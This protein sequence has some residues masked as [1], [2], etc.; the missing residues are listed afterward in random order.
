MSRIALNLAILA[1]VIISA[2]VWAQ[3]KSPDE[4]QFSEQDKLRGS[5]TP[6]RAWWDLQEYHLSIEFMPESKQIRGS[7]VVTFKTLKEATK[8][9]ID[10]QEP[11]NI[12]KVTHAGN[13]L[14]FE[15]DG[16]VYWVNFP[17]ALPIDSEQSI[18]IDYSGTPTE[19]VRPPWQGGVTWTEDEKGQTFIATTCQGIGASIWWPCNC[20][21]YTSP[22]PRDR[23]RSRMP[24]SA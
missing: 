2:P 9:Q 5:I 6:E 20:L 16:N 8:M 3:D 19:S 12:T 23:T 17:T 10:L 11:L 13:E 15:R 22:S 24:S 1:L 21:L 7:N 14:T 4:S 18:T